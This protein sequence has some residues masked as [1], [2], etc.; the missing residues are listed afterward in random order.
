M[1]T[2]VPIDPHAA[3]QTLL[4]WFAAGTLDEA[5]AARVQAHL[6]GCPRCRGDLAFERLL[7]GARPP[8]TV[9]DGAM[10]RGLAALHARIAASAPRPHTAAPWPRR[11][12]DT[13]QRWAGARGAWQAWAG[14]RGALAAQSATVAAAVALLVVVV[15]PPSPDSARYRGLGGNGAPANAVVTFRAGATEADIRAALHGGG[16]RLVDGPTVTGAYLIALPTADA[17]ALARLRAMP[18][19]AQAESLQA[20]PPP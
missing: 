2:V 9:D 19:V 15:L 8:E 10:E 12:H 18:G 7:L 4:P 17:A 3:A 6:D 1:T 16:A 11:W 14:T 20:G 5:D 13:W